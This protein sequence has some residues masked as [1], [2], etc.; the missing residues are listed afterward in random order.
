MYMDSQ[1]PITDEIQSYGVLD[2]ATLQMMHSRE[3]SGELTAMEAEPILIQCREIALTN[4]DLNSQNVE[5]ANAM[6]SL[7]GEEVDH[8]KKSLYHNIENAEKGDEEKEQDTLMNSIL[9]N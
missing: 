3:L 5:M 7:I 8:S 6:V 9:K 2:A 4:A 1:T